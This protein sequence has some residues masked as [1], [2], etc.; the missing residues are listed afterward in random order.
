VADGVPAVVRMFISKQG[1]AGL[2]SLDERELSTEVDVSRNRIPVLDGW[3]GIAIALVLFDHIQYAELRRFLASWTQTGQ[4]GVTLFFVLSGFLITSKLVDG[5]IDLKRFYLRRAFRLLPV[6]FTF[7][8]VLLLFDRFTG[9]RFL[10]LDGVWA[11]LLFY[12]NFAVGADAAAHFWSLSLEEQFYLAWPAILLFAGP[13]KCRWIAALGAVGCAIYRG[14]FW[15]HYDRISFNYE[16]QVRADALLVGCLLALLLADPCARS[17]IKR[18][19]RIWS[20]PALIVLL[21]CMAHYHL[22]TPLCESVSIAMLITASALDP[23]SVFARPLRGKAL[24]YLGV[25]SY[26]LYIWQGPFM[27]FGG[28]QNGLLVIG[29]VMPLFVLGSYYLIERP[30]IRIGARFR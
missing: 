5:P 21:F 15:A 16:T 29:I 28:R 30:C 10:S 6:A 13:R 8:S 7:L 20:L 1:H 11:C 22:L 24:V 3:R 18:W 23:D 19:S 2:T 17:V 25:I 12:R 26:S 27:A 4:H 14:L 9:L